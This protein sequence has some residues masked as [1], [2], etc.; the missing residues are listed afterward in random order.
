MA[1]AGCVKGC[2]GPT[3]PACQGFGVSASVS[4]RGVLSLQLRGR[5][6]YAFSLQPLISFYF[7]CA[8]ISHCKLLVL[9]LISFPPQMEFNLGCLV[10]VKIVGA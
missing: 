10:G 7:S 3:P 6:L 2:V 5:R 9:S 8:G 4:G 1:W